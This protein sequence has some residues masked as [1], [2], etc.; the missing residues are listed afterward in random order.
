MISAEFVRIRNSIKQKVKSFL[1][2]EEKINKYKIINE[3]LKNFLENSAS[4]LND[5]ARF[6]NLILE[7][8]NESDYK[9]VKNRLVFLINKLNLNEEETKDLLYL[10]SYYTLIPLLSPKLFQLI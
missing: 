7:I 4:L 8:K 2:K 6:D 9:R 10:V 1:S 3:H 5:K